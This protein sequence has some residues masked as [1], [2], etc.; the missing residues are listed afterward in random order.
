MIHFSLPE[1]VD[2]IQTPDPSSRVVVGVVVARRRTRRSRPRALS[3]VHAHVRRLIEAKRHA[4][5]NARHRASRVSR[6]PDEDLAR[7]RARGARARDASTR[8]ARG[9]GG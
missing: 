5:A 8:R 7:G 9:G 3:D 2:F 6:V 1:R 4:R